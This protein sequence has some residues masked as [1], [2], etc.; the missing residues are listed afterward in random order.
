MGRGRRLDRA[1]DTAVRGLEGRDRR[2]VQELS[3]G[4]IRLRGRL[5]YLLDLEVRGGIDRLSASVLDILRLGAFQLSELGGVPDYASVSATVDLAQ[6]L[7]EGRAKGLVN[8]VLRSLLRN[9]T[10]HERFPAFADDPAGHLS[11]WGS[12][13]RWL[14]DR[15]LARHSPDE[16]LARVDA[17]N[18][19]PPLGFVPLGS[20]AEAVEGVEAAGGS[21]R[22][23]GRGSG[24]LWVEGIDPLTLLRAVPGFVQDPGAALVGRYAN[25]PAGAI[26]ADVCAAPGGKA[27]YVARRAAYVVAC[28]PSLPRLRVLKE[29]VART[30]LPI[31]VVCARA[32]TSPVAGAD[33]VLV[34]VPCTGTGTLRRHPDA[35]WRLRPEGPGELA[36]VQARLMHGVARA[37]PS[38]GLLVYSTCTLEPEENE[39]QVQSF[40]DDN[41][42]FHLE[43]PSG[44]ALPD[45]TPEGLL[46]VRPET[47]GF[48]GAFAARFRR[49]G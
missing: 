4:S 9:G 47:S 28:D 24:A 11:T 5:D 16:I 31:G 37:V 1:F 25:P 45:L 36:E 13:P 7:G 2:F 35:R 40:L 6:E 43:A 46:S 20:I 34:D 19:V 48:D 38:G 15:W 18:R 27:L 32:E 29:N 23:A 26:V 12:H 22:P 10:G 8:G 44:V 39:S 42:D 41:P 17:A 33:V 49:T 21:A 3:Y 14:I 30:G